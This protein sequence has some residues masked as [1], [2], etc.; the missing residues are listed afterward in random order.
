MNLSTYIENNQGIGILSTA[1]SDGGVN[2]AVYAK[3]HV[4]APDTV[5]FIMRDRLSRANLQQ[6]RH[7]HFLFVEEGSKSN[8]IRLYLDKIF[9]TDD[10]EQI[11]RFSRRKSSEDDQENRYFVT[12]KVR[13]ARQLVGGD[14]VSLH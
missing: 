2:G 7:A 6:N 12:F 8:G 1:G 3:P 14:E 5:G 13:K 11:Q 9:E 4:L 10:V